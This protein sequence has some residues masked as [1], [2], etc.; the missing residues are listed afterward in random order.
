MMLLYMYKYYSYV[1]K[2]S[3]RKNKKYD[4]YKKEKYLLSFGDSRFQHYRDKIGH[5]KE[6]D[7]KD[8]ERR[9]RYYKR[10]TKNYPKYSADWFSKK[11]LW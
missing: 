11:F 4:V 9:A 1:I 7:H 2:P 6:L 8:K 3:T 5:Y 10:H